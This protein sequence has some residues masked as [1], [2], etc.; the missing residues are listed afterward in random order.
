M[1]NLGKIRD[2]KD[3][4]WAI[5]LDGRLMKTMY[6]DPLFIPSRPLAIALAEEWDRQL[7]TIDM[8]TMHLNTMFSKAVR[9]LYDEED[10]LFKYQRKEIVK[11]LNNDNICFI[12][13]KSNNSYTEPLRL[14]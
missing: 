6:K 11:V 7:A 13:P 4:M 8:R 14:I 10:Y 9:S 1:T 12:E 3:K 2:G 5:T